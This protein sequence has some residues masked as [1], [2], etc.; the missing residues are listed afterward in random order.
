MSERVLKQN[1]WR[2]TNTNMPLTATQLNYYFTCRRK[3]WLFS[4][5]ITCEQESELVKIGKIQHE[6]F[7]NEAIE[8]DNIKIDKLKDGKVYELKKKNTAPEAARFQVLFYLAKLKEKGIITSGL[9]KYKE[10]NRVE[11]VEL[12][13]DAEDAL[14]QSL[15]QAAEICQ[16]AQPPQQKK[17]KYCKNCSY[18]DLCFS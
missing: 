9:I 15:L 11:S 3:L 12:T 13:Q 16:L 7:K 18:Y 8:I 6:D 2:D 1:S 17:I 10:N 5:N 14:H 4:H